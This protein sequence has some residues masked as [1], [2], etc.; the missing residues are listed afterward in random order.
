MFSSNISCIGWVQ[1]SAGQISFYYNTI[2]W[3]WSILPKP[4]PLVQHS[5]VLFF[6][7]KTQNSVNKHFMVI[8]T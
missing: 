4:R 8:N 1:K 6:K 3:I 2:L 5:S 7:Q